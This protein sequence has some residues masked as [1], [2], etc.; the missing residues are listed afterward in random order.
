MNFDLT[1]LTATLAIGVLF[2]VGIGFVIMMFSGTKLSSLVKFMSKTSQYATIIILAFCFAVGMIVEDVSN[3]FV[4]DES[5][6]S[7]NGILESD[8]EI[9]AKVFFGNNYGQS[10]DSSFSFLASKYGLLGKYGGTDGEALEKHILLNEC[11]PNEENPET[12][13]CDETFK[14]IERSDEINRIIRGVAKTFYYNA[15]GIAYQD[16]SYYNE[17]KRIQM[18]IDFSRSLVA[19]SIFLLIIVT[20]VLILIIISKPLR[21]FLD[22]ILTFIFRRLF[23]LD[24][25]RK[26]KVQKI[27]TKFQLKIIHYRHNNLKKPFKVK[28]SM[29]AGR[30]LLAYITLAIIFFVAQFAYSSEEREFDR[31]TYGYYLSLEINPQDPKDT[32]PPQKCKE[33][34]SIK[35]ANQ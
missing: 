10:I 29:L 22:S 31:R 9:K 28:F 8:D 25:R 13:F 32:A 23:K 35:G 17:L 34:I 3:K 11:V 20:L 16:N 1:E 26:P 21:P 4:D 14:I 24:I 7:L 5:W 19:V 27:I 12:F 15:K 18:R 30:L 6:F 2:I 33:K